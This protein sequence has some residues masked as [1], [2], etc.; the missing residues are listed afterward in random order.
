VPDLSWSQLVPYGFLIFAGTVLAAT[1]RKAGRALAR[2]EYPKLA[3]ELDLQFEAPEQ[4]SAVGRISGD[5]QGVSVRVE[6]DERARIVCYLEHDPGLDVR[7]YEHFKRCPAGYETFSLG[8]SSANQW[9]KNRYQRADTDPEPSR[10]ALLGLLRE[11]KPYESRISAFTLTADRL[12][13]VFNFGS[14]AHLPANV[15]RDVLPQIL[16]LVGRLNQ[17]AG[18]GAAVTSPAGG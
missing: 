18:A 15:V 5:I 7:S 10:Q 8:S 16:A 6:S 1:K 14:P 4:A 17:G 12:E 2:R 13:C 3:R 9:L 11:L